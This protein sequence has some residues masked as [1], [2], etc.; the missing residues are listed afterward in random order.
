MNSN[1]ILNKIAELINNKKF[2]ISYRSKN[3]GLWNQVYN[4]LNFKSIIYSE[5]FLDYQKIYH[6][7]F[8]EIID[9]SFIIFLNNKPI[10]LFPA[11]FFK[12]DKKISYFDNCVFFPI[13]LNNENQNTIDLVLD[14]ILSSFKSI[15]QYFNLKIINFSKCGPLKDSNNNYQNLN[16]KKYD[17]FQLY[18]NLENSKE[19][20]KKNLRKSYLNIL[21]KKT[22]NEIFTFNCETDDK[23][24][25][26]DFKKLHFSESK[27]K[28]RSDQSW[29]KQFENLQKGKAIFLYSL[30]KNKLIAGSFFDLT[31]DESLYS[32]GVYNE[33]ARKKFISHYIQEKAI[34]EFKIRKIKWYFLGKYHPNIKDN[35]SKKEYNISFFKKGFSSKIINNHIIQI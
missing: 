16:L 14:K 11:F 34:E 6:D 23:K 21:K 4:N 12:K 25:W 13:F 9:I 1:L 17:N 28:T 15:R 29:E 8:D 35:V 7:H 26:L 20:I 31:S 2:I 3:I 24:I 30:E 32:V 27:K 22:I 10:G 5:S 19:E 18:L 33:S